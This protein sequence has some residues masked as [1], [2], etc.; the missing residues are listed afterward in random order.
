MKLRYLVAAGTTFIAA[1]A[2]AAG[3]ASQHQ[4]RQSQSGQ[5]Q[6]MS[7]SAQGPQGQA[8]QPSQAAM[9]PEIIRKVQQELNAKGYDA[10]PV[11][12]QWGPL[13]QR[14]VQNFQQSQDKLQASGQ[15][16]EQTLTALGVEMEGSAA[17]G[18]SAS[19]QSAA[20]G[21]GAQSGMRLDSDTIK[22][23]QQKLNEKG[24]HSG[25]VSGEMDS[26]TRQALKNFQES[27]ASLKATGQ[28]DQ[29]TLGALGVEAQGAAAGSGS[30]MGSGTQ[31]GSQ[32]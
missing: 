19:G 5:G 10:G 16:D 24:F 3:E 29:Q 21:A 8:S 2:I 13:T 30:G 27:Q 1:G 31:S 11:D 25:S 18:G 23:V 7:Q 20:A 9:S 32:K 15:I 6:S 22:Q 4:G 26:Q 14:A 17:T 12:G 28:I